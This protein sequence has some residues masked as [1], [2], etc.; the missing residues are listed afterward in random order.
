MAK[1]TAGDWRVDREDGILIVV[2]TPDGN[3]I[4]ADCGGEVPQGEAKANAQ[5]ISQSKKMLKALQAID[6]C[7]SVYRMDPLER[8]LEAIKHCQSTARAAIAAATEPP[9]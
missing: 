3:S 5:L 4:I 6:I 1:V 7:K 9:A 2:E 8:A